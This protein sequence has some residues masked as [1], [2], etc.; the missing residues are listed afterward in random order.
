MRQ[1]VHEPA[2]VKSTCA[3]ARLV[4]A[5]GLAKKFKVAFHSEFLTTYTLTKNVIGHTL[6]YHFWDTL[7]Q[8]ST[9][10]TFVS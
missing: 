10:D 3:L 7:V 5:L 4:E 2:M 9:Q 1:T 8:E 6:L